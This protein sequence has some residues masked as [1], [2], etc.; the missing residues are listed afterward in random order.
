M[1]QCLPT[2]Q[3]LGSQLQSL[4]GAVVDS[5]KGE[6]ETV[7]LRKSMEKRMEGKNAGDVIKCSMSGKKYI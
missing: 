6:E 3:P 2:R 4:K 5:P 1:P 7:R